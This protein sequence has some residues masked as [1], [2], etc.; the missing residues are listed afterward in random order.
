[1]GVSIKMKSKKIAV[2]IPC[3]NE[4]LTIAKVV[5]DFKK[6]LP[7]ADIYVYDNNSKDKSV[8]LAA[9]AG[10][11]VR[12]EIRQGKGNVVRT[13]FREI[14]ADCYLMVDADDTYS[15]SSAKAMC[16]LILKDNYDMVVGDRLSSTYFKE[17][18]RLFHN[19][20][21]KIV[22]LLIN[23]LFK[24]NIEDIMSGYRAFSYEFVKSYPVLSKRF[25]IET[26]MTIHAVDK[27]FKIK[28]IPIKYKDRP[29]GSVSKLNTYKDGI[30]V[31]KTIEEL[32][33]EYRPRLFFNT[34]TMTF[35]L[36]ALL[37][38]TPVFIEY[39]KTGLVPKFPSLIVSMISLVIALLLFITGMILEVIAK[40]Q[41]EL[42]ELYLNT[43]RRN[44]NEESNKIK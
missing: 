6:V 21:N 17:N 30:M 34:C 31:I 12:H 24:T 14:E 39:F 15:A 19:S 9:S 36:I 4:E 7:K 38:G 27:N 43:L 40:K 13:M 1:M 22:R 10:A 25:E 44:N 23:K 18:K 11:I 29:V 35:L 8:K 5:K 2:L 28:T 33:K 37:L 16:D 41:K 3:Y 26:E 32:V 42:Y 20:G